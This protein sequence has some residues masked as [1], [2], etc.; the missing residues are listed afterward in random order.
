MYTTIVSMWCGAYDKHLFHGQFT[1]LCDGQGFHVT[2]QVSDWTRV[3]DTQHK[4]ALDRVINRNITT[5][6]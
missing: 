3:S 2:E 4:I 1:I 5:Y 6:Q